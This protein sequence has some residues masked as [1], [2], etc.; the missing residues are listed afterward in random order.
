MQADAGGS[1]AGA[2]GGPRGDVL[3]LAGT[4]DGGGGDI[5]QEQVI[6]GVAEDGA[7]RGLLFAEVLGLGAGGGHFAYEEGDA[8]L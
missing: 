5:G 2:G 7:Q 4:G 1:G 6:E 8:A 3:L